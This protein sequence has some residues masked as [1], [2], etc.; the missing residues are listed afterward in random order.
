MRRIDS[1]EVVE[2]RVRGRDYQIVDIPPGCTH[3]IQ[4]VGSGEMVTLFWASEIFNPDRP[5]TYFLPV[6]V[7]A[8]P[9]ASGEAQ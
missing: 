7:E 2:Y 8:P 1:Q 5:D 6:V 9:A 3:S 4:N